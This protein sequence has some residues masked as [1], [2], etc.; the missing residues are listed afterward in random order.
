LLI[1][2][3]S[4]I[5][6]SLFCPLL[7]SFCVFFHFIFVLFEGFF[8]FAFLDFFVFIV[9]VAACYFVLGFRW[10]F[11]GFGVVGWF[12]FYV[13]LCCLLVGISCFANWVL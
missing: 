3:F 9:A 8:I 12:L 10:L 1:Q 4:I 7:G 13:L 11:L 6:V 2:F 5:A